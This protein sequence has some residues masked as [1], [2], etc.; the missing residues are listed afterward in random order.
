MYEK[1]VVSVNSFL[2]SLY[3]QGYLDTFHNSISYTKSKFFVCSY[4][5]YY[6]FHI[7]PII[8]TFKKIIDIV[9]TKKIT[10]YYIVFQSKILTPFFTN[11]EGKY[12]INFD[13]F[14][15][16]E[17]NYIDKVCKLHLD[18]VDEKKLR[19][20][21]IIDNAEDISE[22]EQFVERQ[23]NKNDIKLSADDKNKCVEVMMSQVKFIYDFLSKITTNKVII[24]ENDHKV[25]RRIV[26]EKKAFISAYNKKK[27]K[28]SKA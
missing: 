23:C 10:S 28:T 12:V 2:I 21:V 11:R 8:Y 6:P 9:I 20:Q 14:K 3:V 25:Y 4:Y 13:H 24:R 26:K 16:P 7:E 1:Y 22:F 18:F 19:L 27:A 5:E 15:F 17:Q